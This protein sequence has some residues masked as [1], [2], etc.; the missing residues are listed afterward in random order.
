MIKRINGRKN[1]T[2][3]KFSS[4]SSIEK[5]KVEISNP[6]YKIYSNFIHNNGVDYVRWVK[7]GT[8]FELY[9]N[10]K[11]PFCGK[12]LTGARVKKTNQIME[13]EPEQYKIISDSKDILEKLDIDIPNFSYKRDIRKLEKRL[14]DCI[15]NKKII[16]NM[17]EM[18]DSYSLN[19]LDINNINKITLS[20]SLKQKFPETNE[21]INEFNQNIKELKTQLGKIMKK[22]KKVVGNNLKKLNDYLNDFSIPYEFSVNSY[23]TIE[24]KATVFLISK[25]DNKHEDR[26]ENLSYGEKNLISLLLFLVSNEKEIVIIDDPASSYDDNRRKIIYDLLFDFHKDN[27]YIVLSHDQVF[28]KYALL[29]ISKLRTNKYLVKTGNIMCL[30]NHNGRCEVKAIAINDFDSLYNQI[31]CFIYNNNLCYYRTI[32]NLRILAE[33]NKNSKEID[34]ITYSYLSAILHSTSK[35]EILQYLEDKNYSE[36]R[37]LT[38]IKEKYNVNLIPIPDDI[39]Q[40]FNYDELTNFEKIA[41]TREKLKKEREGSRKVKSFIEKEFDDIVHLNNRYFVSLNPYK[42]DIFSEHIYSYIENE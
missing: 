14:Y 34:R 33:L 42:F 37:I 28:V 27:T 38:Y 10:N 25:K 36:E 1:L 11:C 15:E 41:Y 39:K 24:K 9:S 19:T 26:T 30:E 3:N 22:T 32:I 21:I 5:L 17:Y 31:T 2:K 13:I 40:N 16:I 18:I 29:A 4:N 8:Q 35:N 12:K 7:E 23:N 20:E 6:K